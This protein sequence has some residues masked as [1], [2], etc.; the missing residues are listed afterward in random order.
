MSDPTLREVIEETLIEKGYRQT[1][2]PAYWEP[3]DAMWADKLIPTII[4]CLNREDS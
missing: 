3:P 1:E 2:D 4:D